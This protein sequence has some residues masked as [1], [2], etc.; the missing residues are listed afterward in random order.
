MKCTKY[1]GK[2]L[3]RIKLW[4]SNKESALSVDFIYNEAYVGPVFWLTEA[5]LHS[6]QTS[7]QR[8]QYHWNIWTSVI[9]LFFDNSLK[10]EH[11]FGIVKYIV[12]ACR[13]QNQL[14]CYRMCCN[15]SL[16]WNFPTCLLSARNP[17]Q[18]CFNQRI[19]FVYGR[20]IRI[21]DHIDIILITMHNNVLFR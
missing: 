21:N 15:S 6:E 19:C 18:V 9:M 1:S 11:Q 5:R 10:K 20:P 4:Y 12:F 16:W 8:N 14:L 13:F 3:I 7:N 2:I 17:A